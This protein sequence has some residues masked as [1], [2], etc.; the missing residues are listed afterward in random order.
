MKNKDEKRKERKG[1]EEK[2]VGKI[3]SK[4]KNKADFILIS[5]RKVNLT[6]YSLMEMLTEFFL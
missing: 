2:G 1:K 5:N 6:L 3:E 4:I